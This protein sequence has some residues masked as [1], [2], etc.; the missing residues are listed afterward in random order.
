[1][2]IEK[3][4]SN[5]TS[6]SIIRIFTVPAFRKGDYAGGLQ[7]GLEQLMKDGRRFVVTPADLQRAKER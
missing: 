6:Q 1:L 5:A 2:G 3:F 4:V 7:A